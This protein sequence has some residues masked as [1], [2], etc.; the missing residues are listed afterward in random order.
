MINYER[1]RSKI[2]CAVVCNNKYGII[3]VTIR[4]PAVSL[5]TATTTIY[6]GNEEM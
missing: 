2:Y 3:I 4:L 5:L 6:D 1:R